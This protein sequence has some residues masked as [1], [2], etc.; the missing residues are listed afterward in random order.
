MRNGNKMR[1]LEKIQKSLPFYPTYEEWKLRSPHL[2]MVPT[3]N[4]F[5]LPMRNGNKLLCTYASHLFQLF[6]L[7]MRNGNHVQSFLFD[8]PDTPLFI[9]PMRNGN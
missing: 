1:D 9:L 6:I 2:C 4:L 8:H 3:H 7:P 5:I